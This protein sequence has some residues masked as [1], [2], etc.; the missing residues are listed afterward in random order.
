MKNNS[1]DAVETCCKMRHHMLQKPTLHV[2]KCDTMLTVFATKKT[3]PGVS[4]SNYSPSW[5]AQKSDYSP[6][7][8]APKD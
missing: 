8:W 2:A 7:W 4:R 3:S 1:P 5:W 6:L